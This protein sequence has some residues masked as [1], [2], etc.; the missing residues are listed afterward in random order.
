MHA[1]RYRLEVDHM[2]LLKRIDEALATARHS[3]TLAAR[4]AARNLQEWTGDLIVADQSS[5]NSP[6]NAA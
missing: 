4:Y 6:A 2:G 1:R 3:Q 5:D